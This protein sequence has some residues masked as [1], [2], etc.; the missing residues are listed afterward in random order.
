MSCASIF[1]LLTI[2]QLHLTPE[3]FFE[4][5]GVQHLRRQSACLS[6]QIDS[7]YLD[8]RINPLSIYGGRRSQDVVV[9]VIAVRNTTTRGASCFDQIAKSVARS[10]RRDARQMS[11]IGNVAATTAAYSQQHIPLRVQSNCFSELLVST[12]RRH[13]LV[14]SLHSLS[15]LP[16]HNATVSGIIECTRLQN[17]FHVYAIRPQTGSIHRTGAH[18][19]RSSQRMCHS[20]RRGCDPHQSI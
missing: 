14:Q 20:C 19:A 7:L 4:V 12:L 8:S 9:F 11:L 18:R 13:V 16:I 3:V 5:L 10:A 15:T 2:Q 17:C 1:E 6:A